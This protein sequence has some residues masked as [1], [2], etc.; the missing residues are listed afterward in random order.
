MTTQTKNQNQSP[1]LPLDIRLRAIE[2]QLYGV[3]P[4]LA[5]SSSSEDKSTLSS[6]GSRK[7]VIRQVRE[8]QDAFERLSRESEGIKRLIEGY[9]QY[10]P[11]LNISTVLPVSS[12]SQQQELEQSQSN[13]SSNDNDTGIPMPNTD[14]SSLLPDQVK[15]TMVME[16][17]ND[18]KEAD[19]TLREIDLLTQRDA[20]GSGQLEDL[21]PLKPN[22]IHAI[23]EHQVRSKELTKVKNDITALLSRYND[24]TSTTS[25]LF[26]DVHH[27]LQYLEDRV[28][29]LETKRR[30]ELESRY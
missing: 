19:R 23:K 15:L 25:D 24:F 16:S 26:I 2:A 28:D 11:L 14:E 12:S 4:S 7:S 6:P 17:A 21:I 20:Q 13:K 27:D 29:R 1:L 18:L 22:L 5:S 30:K 9:D 10:L 3:P 8:S